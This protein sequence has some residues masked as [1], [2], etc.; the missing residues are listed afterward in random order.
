[1]IELYQ[2]FN[3]RKKVESSNEYFKQNLKLE[4]IFWRENSTAAN[5]EDFHAEEENDF[6]EVKVEALDCESGDQLIYEYE[7]NTSN[8]YD[9]E[10]NDFKNE[11]KSNLIVNYSP[12]TSTADDKA[13]SAKKT[14]KTYINKW[15]KYQTKYD[16]NL[17]KFVPDNLNFSQNNI[18]N[19]FLQPNV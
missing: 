19:I 9:E 7:P 18:Y 17:R 15:E 12:T 2:C 11:S 16:Q 14:R 13:K 4:E 1:M 5:E 10:Q 3:F 8:D 6:S